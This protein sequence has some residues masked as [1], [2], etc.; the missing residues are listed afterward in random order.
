[1][2][3][4]WEIDKLTVILTSIILGIP[5]ILFLIV[6][7]SFLSVIFWFGIILLIYFT[8]KKKQKK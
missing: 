1:M 6:F 7:H 5:A 4:T 2:F 8:Y 3:E